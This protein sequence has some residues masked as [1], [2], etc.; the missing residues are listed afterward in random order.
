MDERVKFIARMRD[1]EKMAEVCRDLSA[2]QSLVP[3]A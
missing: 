2:S 3:T 1:G